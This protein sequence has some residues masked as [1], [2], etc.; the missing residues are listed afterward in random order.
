MVFDIEPVFLEAEELVIRNVIDSALTPRERT[1]KL[2]W[3]FKQEKQGKRPPP[4]EHAFPYSA[5][6]DLAQCENTIDALNNIVS[7]EPVSADG[8]RRAYA[9][10]SHVNLRLLRIVTD[11]AEEFKLNRLKAICETLNAL[12]LWKLF[13]LSANQNHSLSTPPHPKQTIP[14][15]WT[16]QL[17]TYR[18]NKRTRKAHSAFPTIPVQSRK[19]IKQNPTRNN[20]K[21]I[22][23]L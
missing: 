23:M 20:M 12:N 16:P 7:T 5:A 22:S 4:G 9:R 6:I 13:D 18:M 15:M 8:T 11:D 14:S 2:N 19:Q 3:L 17:V 21:N 1:S 10:I